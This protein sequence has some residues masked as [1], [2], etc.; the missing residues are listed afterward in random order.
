MKRINASVLALCAVSVGILVYAPAPASATVLCSKQ[1]TP[2]GASIY[3]A[4]T[5]INTWMPTMTTAVL[6]NTLANVTCL[7]WGI[8]I[9]TTNAG[10]K[11]VSVAGRVNGVTVA[12]CTI[13]DGKGGT[14]SCKVTPANFG[15][16]EP[17]WWVATFEKGLN[18]NGQLTITPSSL[19][20]FGLSVVCNAFGGTISC[21]FT[22]GPTFPVTGGV[23]PGSPAKIAGPVKLKPV[24]GPKCPGTEATWKFNWEVW[25]PANFYLEAE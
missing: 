7:Q 13:P 6:E 21:V 1:V 2:C 11:G 22:N 4:E 25:N 20:A 3:P 15:A 23:Y 17:E 14:E 9:K 24:A 5:Q 19:G 16:T 18:G 12:E 10:G 8:A